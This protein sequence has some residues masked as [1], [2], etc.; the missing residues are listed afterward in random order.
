VA[1]LAAVF[2]G[3]LD[4]YLDWPVDTILAWHPQAVRH[5]DLRAQSIATAFAALLIKRS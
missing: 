5:F 4:T 2:G 3:G 1:D